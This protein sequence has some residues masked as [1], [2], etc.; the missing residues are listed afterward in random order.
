MNC[1]NLETRAI[2][3]LDG[4]LNGALRDEVEL[5]LNDCPACRARIEGFRN[6]SLALDAWEAPELSPWFNA[7]LR[8][9]IAEQEAV[10]WNWS[11]LVHA[12][13]RP[14]YVAALAMVLI[15]GSLAVWNAAPAHVPSHKQTIAS[16][17]SVKTDEMLRVA[18]DYDLLNNFDVLPDLQKPGGSL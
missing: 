10:G 13:L 5:H 2:E 17:Q 7:R 8:R 11:E 18:E 4:A 15:V 6:V 14:S 16:Q 9:Y 1:E 12:L 3:Y